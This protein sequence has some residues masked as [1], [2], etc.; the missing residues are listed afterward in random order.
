M[1]IV[2]PK[3]IEGTMR[4]LKL[5][6]LPKTLFFRT[7]LLIFIP[8]IVVQVVS[9]IAYFNGSWGKVGRRLSDNLS[10]NMSFIVQMTEQNPDNFAEV[11]KLAKSV[12]QLDVEYFNNDAKHS[13]RIKTSRIIIWLP[14][15]LNTHWKMIFPMRKHQPIWPTGALF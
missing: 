3:K 8:L 12:Y 7:M 6:L 15:F 11:Q 4:Y 9:I 5:K 1:H 13:E 2:F 14:A 10:S